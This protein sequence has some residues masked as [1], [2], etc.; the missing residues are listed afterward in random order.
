MRK[1]TEYDDGPRLHLREIVHRADLQI[2]E[3]GI[4]FPN[5]HD[6]IILI[7]PGFPIISHKLSLVAV[8]SLRHLRHKDATVS[9][10][11]C[12]R[13][14]REG[15]VEG[16]FGL[17][18]PRGRLVVHAVDAKDWLG[19]KQRRGFGR[20]DLRLVSRLVK[21]SWLEEVDLKDNPILTVD[22]V[23]IKVGI[24]K[25]TF[26]EN[27][28]LSLEVEI[29]QEPGD[30]VDTVSIQNADEVDLANSQSSRRRIRRT[31]KTQDV[32]ERR[33]RILTTVDIQN[34]SEADSSHSRIA[35]GGQEVA[36]RKDARSFMMKGAIS[37]RLD[38]DRQTLGQGIMEVSLAGF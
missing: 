14:L 9:I 24:S 5:P 16:D 18:Q 37:E 7:G 35:E 29:S 27:E 11:V 31:A 30:I 38:T 6:S 4:C 28:F 36:Q 8:V 22:G 25:M 1:T 10:L 26:L 34:T 19:P 33:E 20:L 23:Q 17:Y 15:E 2:Y 21:Q 32:S 12:R 3:Y 13:P